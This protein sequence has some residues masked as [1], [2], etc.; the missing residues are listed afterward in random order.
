MRSTHCHAD[1]LSLEVVSNGPHQ[2]AAEP[3]PAR[4]QGR[5]SQL[6]REVVRLAEEASQQAQEKAARRPKLSREERKFSQTKTPNLYSL[7]EEVREL[8]LL[9]PEAASRLCATT[10]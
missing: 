3:Q 2:R 8:A 7:L 4:S 6:V 9:D 10:A 1:A 5:S